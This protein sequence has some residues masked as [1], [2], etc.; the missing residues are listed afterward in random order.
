MTL[1]SWLTPQRM[2]LLVGV[3]FA[4][5]GLMGFIPGIMRDFDDLG[6]AGPDSDA[7]WLGVGQLSVLHN[8]MHLV[9]GAIGIAVS[10]ST[11]RA[12]VLF[13]LIGGAIYGSFGIYGFLVGAESSANWAPTNW[14][15]DMIHVVAGAGMVVMGVLSQRYYGERLDP[16]EAPATS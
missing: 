9:I 4:A 3:G 7:M 13:L 15:D 6:L 2:A 16:V 12:C 1:T 14:F 10:R 11:V 8:V 5:F